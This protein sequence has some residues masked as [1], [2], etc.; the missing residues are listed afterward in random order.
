DQGG[1]RE[2][3]TEQGDREHRRAHRL[4]Q[5]DHGHGGRADDGGPG[6][7]E[8]V[9]QRRRHGGDVGQQP[10]QR[11]G[12]VGVRHQALERG[13]RQQYQAGDGE[14]PHGRTGGVRV[15]V[16]SPP[17]GEQGHRRVAGRGQQGEQHAPRVHARPSTAQDEDDEPGEG[18][19]DGGQSAAPQPFAHGE[20]G[21]ERD[22]HG[23]GAEGDH[24]GDGQSGGGDGR[25][26]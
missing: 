1:R 8:A 18:T 2:P 5:H 7:V 17:A 23:S 24:G 9:R 6:E 25:E 20:P 4:Q 10:Q 3:L 12:G 11:A 14:G 22:Q 19:G 16:A 15:A 13:E 21:T 26:V